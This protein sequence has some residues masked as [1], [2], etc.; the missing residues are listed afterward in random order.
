MK[1]LFACPSLTV[2]YHKNLREYVPQA[3]FCFSFT[4]S[5]VIQIN[6]TK[7]TDAFCTIKYRLVKYYRDYNIRMGPF[8]HFPRSWL[9][10][11][12]ILIEGKA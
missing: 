6:R 11:K 3:F 10:R 5:L 7:Q 4:E 8:G 12:I 2:K 9:Y 1:P